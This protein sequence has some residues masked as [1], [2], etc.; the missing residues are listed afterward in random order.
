MGYAQVFN[1]I[2]KG[3]LIIKEDVSPDVLRNIQ[4]GAKISRH[5]KRKFYRFFDFF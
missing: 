3:L 4:N 2:H 5:I 1:G